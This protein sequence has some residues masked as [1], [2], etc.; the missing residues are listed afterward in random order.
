MFIKYNPEWED[1]A[2]PR[3]QGKGGLPV[4][5]LGGVGHAGRRRMA[6]MGVRYRQLQGATGKTNWWSRTSS[7]GQLRKRTRKPDVSTCQGRMITVSDP[8]RSRIPAVGAGGLM[9]HDGDEWTGKKCR[10]KRGFVKLYVMAN[11]QPAKIVV[12]PATDGSAGGAGPVPSATG[13]GH[14]HG[15]RRGRRR[16][17]GHPTFQGSGIG[18]PARELDGSPPVPPSSRIP[19]SPRVGHSAPRIALVEHSGGSSDSVPY[20]PW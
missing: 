18:R 10:V 20:R 11:P 7:F 9:L 14:G 4:P 8:K 15:W 16:G 6:G 12:L 13:T 5:V 3:R 17:R 19:E 1:G 2:R